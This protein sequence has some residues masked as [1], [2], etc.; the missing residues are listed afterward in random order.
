MAL[1]FEATPAAAVVQREVFP[2][3]PMGDDGQRGGINDW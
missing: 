3:G 1:P 2:S